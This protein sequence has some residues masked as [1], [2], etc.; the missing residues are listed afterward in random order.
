MRFSPFFP[1]DFGGSVEIR[2][3]FFFDFPCVIILS[4]NKERKDR[5]KWLSIRST[6]TKGDS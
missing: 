6:E 4:K 2:H 5:V 1:K 3:P